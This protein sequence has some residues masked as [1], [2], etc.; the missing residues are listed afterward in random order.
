[1]ESFLEKGIL[2]IYTSIKCVTDRLTDVEVAE[3]MFVII[4]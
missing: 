3:R 1:M 2:V 4:D